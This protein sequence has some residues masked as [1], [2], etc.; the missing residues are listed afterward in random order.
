MKVAEVSKTR[1]RPIR[2]ESQGQDLGSAE[3]HEDAATG[4]QLAD[5]TYSESLEEALVC[6]VPPIQD[7]ER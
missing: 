1:L 5:G 6:A 2:G 7:N 4:A 3:T